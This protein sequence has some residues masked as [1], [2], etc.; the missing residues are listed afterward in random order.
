MKAWL[1]N[2]AVRHGLFWAAVLGLCFL[3]QLPAHFII[4][5]PLYVW[6]LFFNQL[7]A[8]LLATYPLLYWILPRLLRQQQLSFLGLLAG[9]LLAAILLAN[10]TRTLY[11]F[12][13]GPS[14]F[15]EVP[16]RTFQWGNYLEL[17][18]TWFVLLVAAGAAS[19]IKVTN[20]WY[21]QRQRQQALLQRKLQ[22]ELQSLK[23]QLQP[24]FLFNTLR[25]LHV[26]TAQKSPASPAAVLQLS[27]L[28]RYMLYESPLDAVPLADEAEMMRHYV[29]LEELRG[30]SRVEVSLN[31]SG[32]LGA[33]FIA[34][35]LLLPFVENAFRDGTGPQ[36]ECPWVSIDLVAKK[37]S[38]TFKVINSQTQ[39]PAD[40]GESAG[41]ASI[42]QRLA[43]LYPGRHELKVVTEPDAFLIALH[44]W[45]APTAQPSRHAEP[46]ETALPR[47]QN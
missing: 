21:E 16:G 28:L 34:P 2:R 9:W 40:L 27:A 24:T 11:D 12:G 22:A 43:R 31:F 29:A 15:G 23:A 4:G 39:A 45:L 38:I 20:G 18:Y 14:W 30:G 47:A 33:H 32:A 10:A 35:L 8:L 42:R 17:D 13:L 6:G 26:L 46:A 3:I 7:P 1:H 5:T 41:L 44:L 36:Q 19:A 37:T 25:T